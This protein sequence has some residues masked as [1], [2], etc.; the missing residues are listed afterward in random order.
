MKRTPKTLIAIC[1]TM[2]SGILSYEKAAAVNDVSGRSI[3]QWIKMSQGDDPELIIEYLGEE[4]Q[5]ARALIGARR[6]ALHEARGRMEQKSILGYEEPIFYNG[7]P[8]WQPDPA[9]VGWTEDERADLGFP[10][11]GLLRDKNGCTIQNSLH[12]EPPVALQLRVVEAAFPKEY[13]P[14]VN[15]SV[16]VAH[17]GV[18]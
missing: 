9:C 15:Q 1:D 4:V 11:D 7:M 13:R 16:D 10:R 12:H 17:S 5:F 6:I 14:G 2:A 3:W 8:T 18:V